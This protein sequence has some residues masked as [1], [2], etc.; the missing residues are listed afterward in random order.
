MMKHVVLSIVAV[1]T[2]AVSIFG[3]TA[4]S[5]EG[6]DKYALKVPGGL[7]FSD[8][9]GYE[10]WQTIS[11]SRNDHAMAVIVGNP[12]MI[13]AYQTGIPANGQPFPDGA[14]MAKIHWTP[15]TSEYPGAPSVPAAQHDVDFMVKDRKRFADSGGWGYAVFEYDPASKTFRPGT[16]DDTPP[17]ANDAKCGFAC[18]TIVKTRD[19]VFTDYAPR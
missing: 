15:K 17:Q 8:F 14:R 4:S 10:S 18:H 13:E 6:N 7:A 5:A 19:Y 9:K 12:A 2:L 1:A 3:A 11:V 16:T